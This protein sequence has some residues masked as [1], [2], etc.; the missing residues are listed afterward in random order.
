MRLFTVLVF[1]LS[2][3]FMVAQSDS[4][5]VSITILRPQK[6]SFT[7][8]IGSYQQ[9]QDYSMSRQVYR[10]IGGGLGFGDSKTT[11]NGLQY[12]FNRFMYG[13][14]RSQGGVYTNQMRGHFGFGR[15]WNIGYGPL[16]QLGF[17]TD[18]L[19]QV[20]ITPR[21]SNSSLHWD[22]VGSLGAGFRL[23]EHVKLPLLKNPI[24]CFVQVTLPLVAYINRPLYAIILSA[25]QEQDHQLGF[26]GPF[27]RTT[28]ELGFRFPTPN[29]RLSDQMRL[30]YQWDY[31]SWRGG[32]EGY[33]VATAA[34][35]I[36]LA[37]ILTKPL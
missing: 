17:H 29:Y 33:T 19:A 9:V 4:V 16:M 30:S 14:L 5:E 35:S 31:F 15:L 20:R 2:C 1:L 25:G 27:F 28:M 34:H 22:L 7:E 6:Y 21:L 26:L 23:S 10:G 8:L 13:G 32:Q 36:H 11:S 3:Q 37:F 12:Y 24:P 18:L